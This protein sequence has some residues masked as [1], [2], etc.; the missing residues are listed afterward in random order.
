M[1]N[2]L[3]AFDE[4][5]SPFALTVWVAADSQSE[6]VE[7]LKVCLGDYDADIHSP[8]IP[9]IRNG[10]VHLWVH[11]VDLITEKNIIDTQPKEG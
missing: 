3:F 7:K 10:D 4:K 9:G 2:Y 11:D 5:E 6:A 1:P 8:R